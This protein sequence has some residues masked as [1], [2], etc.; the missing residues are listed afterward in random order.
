MVYTGCMGGFGFGFGGGY[1]GMIIGIIIWIAIIFAVIWF[2]S[3]FLKSN[4][5]SNFGCNHSGHEVK[6]EEPLDI[7]KRR[8]A[9][10]E[11]GKKDFEKMKKELE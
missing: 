7:L 3:K 4:D 2:A 9:Q 11:I 1:L 5:M 6:Q 8:Y 10:G